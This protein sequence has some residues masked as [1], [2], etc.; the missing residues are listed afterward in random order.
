MKANLLLNSWAD[1]SSH[2]DATIIH[3]WKTNKTIPQREKNPLRKK[4][5]K[6]IK[7]SIPDYSGSV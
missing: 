4:K 2:F 6:V 7:E 3:P 1:G 5:K